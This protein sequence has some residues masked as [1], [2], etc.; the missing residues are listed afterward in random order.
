MNFTKAKDKELQEF[1]MQN[2]YLK[3]RVWY[4]QMSLY[5]GLL[6]LA[7]GLSILILAQSKELVFSSAHQS[8]LILAKRKQLRKA[9]PKPERPFLC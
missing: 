5:S 3:R 2:S 4:Y 9:T 1:R 8:A 6:A 7:A